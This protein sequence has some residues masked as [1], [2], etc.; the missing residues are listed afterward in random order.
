[1]ERKS[2]LSD[3]GESQAGSASLSASKYVSS[4]PARELI[5]LTVKVESHQMDYAE[6]LAL[7]SFLPSKKR[8]VDCLPEIR[9]ITEAVLLLQDLA[10]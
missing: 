7:A 3:F 1:M 5:G 8:L 6:N 4:Q 2:L 10:R 9:K